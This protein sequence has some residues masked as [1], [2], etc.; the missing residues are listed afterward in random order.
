[1]GA[2]R[3]RLGLA[4]GIGGLLGATTCSV[5]MVLGIVAGAGVASAAAGSSMSGM[6]ST[7]GTALNQSPVVAFLIREGPV[8]LVVSIIAL[9]LSA[10]LR[11]PWAAV[12]TVLAGAVLYAGMYLQPSVIVMYVAIALG[13]L[14][15][16]AVVIWTNLAKATRA[17][18]VR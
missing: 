7:A 12:P 18:S 6:S 16:T 9:T 4:A 1:M 15:W 10:G 13:L 3:R 8:I 2:S 17:H 14:A 11:R 5:S